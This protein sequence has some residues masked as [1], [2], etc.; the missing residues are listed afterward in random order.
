MNMDKFL[1]FF[2][3]ESDEESKKR[4]KE[5]FEKGMGAT[6]VEF[7][8][9]YEEIKDLLVDPFKKD[10]PQKPVE[11]VSDSKE[12]PKSENEISEKQTPE[13][14]GPKPTFLEVE[15][16]N[17]KYVM[18]NK[19]GRRILIERS[20]VEKFQ[21]EKGIFDESLAAIGRKYGSEVHETGAAVTRN[22]ENSVERVNTEM[23]NRPEVVANI[24]KETGINSVIT[25]AGKTIETIEKDMGAAMK[26][27]EKLEA[28]KKMYEK[29]LQRLGDDYEKLESGKP[30][31]VTPELRE[32]REYVFK[33]F[34]ACKE[35]IALVDKDIEEV[36]KEITN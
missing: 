8:K 27:M 7:N 28:E 36:M 11:N 29:M 13:N 33:Q 12:T 22:A 17:G 26:R 2:G 32:D 10:T 31:S 25:E 9:K 35:S 6:G 15:G 1:K 24:Q 20:Q 3:G 34:M 16:T 5:I 18:L 14:V 23:S 21:R 30:Y 4:A 19:T